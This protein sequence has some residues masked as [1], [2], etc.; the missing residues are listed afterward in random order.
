MR[1]R[2]C[3]RGHDLL[4]PYGMTPNGQC[5]PCQAIRNKARRYGLSTK[6]YLEQSSKGTLPELVDKREGSHSWKMRANTKFT[7]CKRGH[8]IASPGTRT[9]NGNCR[10]CHNLRVQANHRGLG[11]DEYWERLNGKTLETAQSS[12]EV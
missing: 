5:R 12:D 9:W 7:V 11:I 3:R 4:H 2:Y 8:D 6:D 10:T 1:S